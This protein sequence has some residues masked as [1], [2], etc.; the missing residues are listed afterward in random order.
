MRVD[1]DAE[2]EAGESIGQ[3]QGSFARGDVPSG[4]QDPLHAGQART[5][6]DEIGVGVEAIRVEVAVAVDET[7]DGGHAGAGSVASAS[8]S[9]RGNSG[10]GAVT[11]PASAAWAPQASSSRIGGPP[12]PSA[13]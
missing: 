11:R 12:L 3:G 6:Q 10:S 4:H 1:A 2:I 5:T 8:S 9:S 7:R 13:S